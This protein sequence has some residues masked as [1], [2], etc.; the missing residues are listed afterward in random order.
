MTGG[1]NGGKTCSG[2]INRHVLSV[3]ADETTGR[4]VPVG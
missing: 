1:T 2:I 4:D 3:A